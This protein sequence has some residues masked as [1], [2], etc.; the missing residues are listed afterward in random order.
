[1][2]AIAKGGDE[3]TNWYWQRAAPS[4]DCPNWIARW[5]LYHKFRYRD[6]RNR[7]HVKGSEDRKHHDSK[8]SKHHK[9]KG[10]QSNEYASQDDVYQDGSRTAGVLYLAILVVRC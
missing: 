10:H 8:Q 1:M 5:F 2:E 7:T 6:G 9:S 4:D 3:Y